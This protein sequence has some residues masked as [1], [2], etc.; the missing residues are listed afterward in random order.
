MSLA[1]LTNLLI[2][3]LLIEMM[4]AV[5]L[6]VSLRDVGSVFTDWNLI[7]RAAFANYV[8]VPAF[9]VALLFLFHPPPLIRAFP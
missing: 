3:I 2:V 7:F 5:G 9:T 4:I 1:Q 8:L 6:S